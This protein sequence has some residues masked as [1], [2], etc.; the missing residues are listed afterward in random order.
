MTKRHLCISIIICL[1]FSLSIVYADN[2]TTVTVKNEIPEYS[3]ESSLIEGEG[4]HDYEDSNDK[5]FKIFGKVI[6]TEYLN[7]NEKYVCNQL[8][9]RANDI[10]QGKKESAKVPIKATKLIEKSKYTYDE[11]GITT[12]KKEVDGK[13]VLSDE[14]NKK[15]FSMHNIDRQKVRN[16]I[17]RDNPEL[18]W[19]D[20]DYNIY[21]SI[22]K[23]KYDEETKI[24]D[25]SDAVYTYSLVVSSNYRKD[26]DNLYVANKELVKSH[27]DTVITNSKKVINDA[28]NNSETIY[29]IL[30]YYRNYI[31][32]EVE[33]DNNFIEYKELVE[34]DTAER[35]YRDQNPAHIYNAL[36]NN[37]ET[38][39]ICQGYAKAFK[40]LCDNT[41]NLTKRGI[42]VYLAS[43]ITN[44]T[45][46][47]SHM[48][49][50]VHFNNNKNYLADITWTDGKDY[51]NNTYFMV[52]GKETK[53]N[54]NNESYQGE[55]YLFKVKTGKEVSYTYNTEIQLMFSGDQRR[56]S[57]TNYDIKTS[58][59]INTYSLDIT[60]KGLDEE[61]TKSISAREYE[62]LSYDLENFDGYYID[63]INIKYFDGKEYTYSSSDLKK[64]N[65]LSDNNT[66]ND[67][68]LNIN[69]MDNNASIT[70]NYKK[71]SNNS[72]SDKPNV[73]VT[74]NTT[75]NTNINNNNTSGTNNT[76]KSTTDNIKIENYTDKIAIS[77][78]GWIVDGVYT[79][80]GSIVDSK[81]SLLNA[82]KIIV[83]NDSTIM[84]VAKGIDNKYY[85]LVEAG[86][87][88][89]V[90]NENEP[91]E[92]SMLKFTSESEN[93][94]II[95]GEKVISMSY[96]VGS[97]V[98][99]E[100][101]Y[102]VCATFKAKNTSTR[103][104]GIFELDSTVQDVINKPA[105][106]TSQEP[107][108]GKAFADTIN[109]GKV[110]RE[111]TINN[112][113]TSND[114]EN[115]NDENVNDENI[116]DE[117]IVSENNPEDK[118]NT[119]ETSKQENKEK[120]KTGDYTNLYMY[121]MFILGSMLI[122]VC[123]FLVNYRRRK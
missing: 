105:T 37:S 80:A 68:K 84:P 42:E 38:N 21:T 29:D 35:I 83:R 52:G 60:L 109:S 102:V 47:S 86:I 4:I 66:I 34:A 58:P 18:F 63:S 25:F 19:W 16:C 44:D 6:D 67:K 32:K 82:P 112:K 98:L 104:K 118:Q 100:K 103:E 108:V 8:L 51:T 114:N 5:P 79:K 90:D 85:K 70:I 95:P 40:Y 15:V 122:I 88:I 81:E 46:D 55:R 75:N 20:N 76:E 54:N 11:L 39:I 72:T 89:N 57:S 10:S 65:V 22:S 28:I 116:D 92:E 50:I 9:L 2:N 14:L 96:D 17:Y 97:I 120:V 12:A 121:I 71:V 43:G 33:Y 123:A 49:N 13:V 59:K 30:N 91:I 3:K 7:D 26:F 1:L 48:W 78:Y 36:D 23:I 61:K 113:N 115:V 74:N 87:Y 56:L 73:N 111:T 64:D 27:Y 101:K 53:A 94:I 107:G 93:D 62:K 31:C 99:N 45:Y 119:K 41:P 117:E 110:D 77:E 106:D 24:V 69:S